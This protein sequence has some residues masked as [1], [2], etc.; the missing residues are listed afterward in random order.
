MKD[1][2]L[3]EKPTSTVYLIQ[4]N[5]ILKN[6]LISVWARED[7]QGIPQQLETQKTAKPQGEINHR[8]GVFLELFANPW[9]TSN[10]N[11]IGSQL[12]HKDKVWDLSRS[13]KTHES[14]RPQRKGTVVSAWKKLSCLQSLWRYLPTAA[15]PLT[16]GQDRSGKCNGLSFLTVGLS[17]RCLRQDYLYGPKYPRLEM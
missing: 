13:Q 6:H 10:P 7:S 17:L 15:F 12:G 16:V 14:Q 1:K 8:V 4:L 11:L 2:K 5:S 9:E 3:S